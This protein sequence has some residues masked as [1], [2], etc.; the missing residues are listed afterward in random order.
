MNNLKGYYLNHP[1]L[2]SVCSEWFIF[3]HKNKLFQLSVSID[4]FHSE[5]EYDLRVFSYSKYRNDDKKSLE[6]IVDLLKEKGV[7]NTLGYTKSALKR[8]FSI[9][10]SIVV[11]NELQNNTSLGPY[12]KS[13]LKEHVQ[14]FNITKSIGDIYYELL[15]DRAS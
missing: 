12:L 5:T 3:T 1:E 7:E 10:N 15:L 4:Q 9:L 13:M 11:R 14:R 6:E 8:I 2:D